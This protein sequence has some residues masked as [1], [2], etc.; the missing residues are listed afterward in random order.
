MYWPDPRLCRATTS[1]NQA[2]V[3]RSH[4][5]TVPSSE[6][7]RTRPLQNC[8]Q[9]TADWCLL[10]PENDI[11]IIMTRWPLTSSQQLVGQLFMSMAVCSPHPSLSQFHSL[12]LF[13]LT[14][15]PFVPLFLSPRDDV[16]KLSRQVEVVLHPHTLSEGY[17]CLTLQRVE[18]L[19]R[20]DVPH[21]DGGVSIPGRQDVVS[22][23]HA[24]GERLVAG[25]RV[26]TSTWRRHIHSHFISNGS[27]LLF[28]V[29]K[30]HNE[31][32]VNHEQIIMMKSL[33]WLFTVNHCKNW[34]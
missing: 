6:L 21:S 26:N 23:F 30:N 1:L 29:I 18:T 13:F 12:I 5:L 31:F 7:D 14:S 28:K 4:S 20:S 3:L 33:V 27:K 10:G 22:Q 9:V 32:F 16:L 11:I 15:Q 24:A 17:C 19:S 8:R 34:C 2:P 25:Q